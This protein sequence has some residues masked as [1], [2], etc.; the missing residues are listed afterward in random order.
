MSNVSG[1][2]KNICR[3]IWDYYFELNKNKMSEL[4]NDADY[5]LVNK[6]IRQL[7]ISRMEF[8]NDILTV[9]LNRPGIFIGEK[10]R[11]IN[12]IRDCLSISFKRKIDIKIIEDRLPE[13]LYQYPYWMDEDGDW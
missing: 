11:N 13:C 10:G 2:V 1:E 8:E 5:A 3:I 9:Y 6:D 4:L 12:A 7:G